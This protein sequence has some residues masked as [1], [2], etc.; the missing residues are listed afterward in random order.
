MI[1]TKNFEIAT[2]AESR[3]A[4]TKHANCHCEERK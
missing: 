3:L 4:K 1:C 2:A